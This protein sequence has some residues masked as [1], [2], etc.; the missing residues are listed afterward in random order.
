MTAI[1]QVV[2]A[3]ATTTITLALVFFVTAAHATTAPQYIEQCTVDLGTDQ[4]TQCGLDALFCTGYAVLDV[5]SD[6]VAVQKRGCR[7]CEVSP[8]GAQPNS[9]V[10]DPLNVCN[11][12][13]GEFCR[14]TNSDVSSSNRVV[15]YCEQSTLVDTNCSIDDDCKGVRESSTDGGFARRERGHC[16]AGVCRQCD[17]AAFVVTYGATS[18]ACPGYT[19]QLD[20]TRVYNNARPGTRVTCTADGTLVSDG[21]VDFQVKAGN[22]HLPSSSLTPS[23]AP[24][25]S[26]TFQPDDN[27]YKAGSYA[28]F[29]LLSLAALVCCLA[30]VS[31]LAYIVYD[32]RRNA[33]GSVNAQRLNDVQPE[34]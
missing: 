32:K 13:G 8:N 27:N 16:V 12:A 5:N 7:P 22:A 34:Q 4:S 2:F 29:A 31:A 14:H 15:G 20:G 30:F 11:C 33:R 25:A 18:F 17:P 24:S 19:E 23:S 28:G 21:T 6:G 1:V 26:N 9:A 3:V 10:Y